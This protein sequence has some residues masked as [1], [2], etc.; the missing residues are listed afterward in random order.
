M[1]CDSP[2]SVFQTLKEKLNIKRNTL[3]PTKKLTW[4]LLDRIRERLSK[5]L[6]LSHVHIDWQNKDF[7]KRF[8]DFL[9]HH[10]EWVSLSFILRDMTIQEILPKFR[11]NNCCI[12]DFYFSGLK[13]PH[14]RQTWQVLESI[15]KNCGYVFG[16]ADLCI[17]SH[18]P[19]QLNYDDC[20]YVHSEGKPAIEFA[21]GQLFYF[22]HGEVIPEKYG[23]YNP[24]LWQKKWFLQEKDPH[25]QIILARGIDFYVKT[26]SSE[27]E[28]L[29]LSY[30]NRWLSIAFSTQPIVCDRVIQV[31]QKVYD[32]LEIKQPNII[33]CQSLQE[34]ECKVTTLNPKR[35]L[36]DKISRIMI[37]RLYSYIDSQIDKTLRNFLQS[38]FLVEQSLSGMISN[39]LWETI[40]EKRLDFND[41]DLEEKMTQRLAG[42]AG[43]LGAV[44]GGY[45]DFCISV[46]N[47]IHNTQLWELY[48]GLAIE[49]EYVFPYENVCFVCDRPRTLSFD[50]ENR[51]HAEEKPAIEFADGFSV[52]AYHGVRLPEKYGKLPPSQWRSQWILSEENAEIRRT[53]I[54]GIGYTRICQELQAVA[55]DT[56]QEYSLLKIDIEFD[57]ELEEE[58]IYLLKMTCP[59]T[60][61]IHVLRVPPNMNSARE[62]ITWVNWDIDPE[63]FAVQT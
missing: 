25:L 18:R 2:L 43:R 33:F 62:A 4:N 28:K 1:F 21:D 6:Q 34:V 41:L 15:V 63:K 5:Q 20:G 56:W 22:Y 11:I 13:Y 40:E 49:C 9:W 30:C 7:L 35:C 36:T 16:F 23:K 10:Q 32:F 57:E 37:E 38:K 48:Q 44:W 26:L 3:T 60:G 27:Q 24:D 45:L 58:P 29:L 55:L 47:C 61:H 39:A 54:Q 53:L 42:I 59:S 12:L 19:K 14:S 31:I 51:L 8:T 17:I 52:Y 46:L 50:S